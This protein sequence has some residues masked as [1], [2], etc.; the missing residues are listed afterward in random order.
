MVRRD[1]PLPL[2][3]ARRRRDGLAVRHDGPAVVRP[4]AARRDGR[5]HSRRAQFR[6]QRQ[7][8]A[9]H[10]SATRRR[11][12]DVDLH[13]RL[14]HRRP[15]FR[16]AGGPH[17]PRENDDDDGPDVLALHGT[18]L[19]FAQHVGFRFLPL[20]YGAGRR[21]RV[22][23]RRGPGGR[24]HAQLG[25]APIAGTLAGSFRHRERECRLHLSRLG[26]CPGTRVAAAGWGGTPYLVRPGGSCS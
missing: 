5:S 4:G 13:R 23:R 9:R 7:Q 11:L 15:V 21:G 19:L 8:D 24:S 10:G 6:R 26:R 14:G 22:C 2:V 18:E 1:D 12:R 3:R 16:H 25:A 20:S 17:R